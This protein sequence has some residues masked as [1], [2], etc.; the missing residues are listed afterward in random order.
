MS[1]HFPLSEYYFFSSV[2]Y[3]CPH[4]N[5]LGSIAEAKATGHISMPVTEN[6]STFAMIDPPD[7]AGATA[8]IFI[9]PK[10]KLQQFLALRQVQVHGPEQKS[11]ADKAAALSTAVEKTITVNPITS[12]AYRCF[13]EHW[14]A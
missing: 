1:H 9:Q 11:F 8:A 14:M 10:E 12:E 7:V 4:S 6:T 3:Q 13:S 5:W 2:S